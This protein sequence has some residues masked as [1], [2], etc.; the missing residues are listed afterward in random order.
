MGRT[1]PECTGIIAKEEL[2][3]VATRARHSRRLS[4]MNARVRAGF[5]GAPRSSELPSLHA[6]RGTR[7]L[8]LGGSSLATPDRIRDVGR[9]VAEHGERH[10]AIVVVSAFQGV[11]NQLLDC[12]RAR[13]TARSRVRTG[14]RPDRRAPSFRDRQSL[15]LPPGTLR[16]A[17][18]S[19]SSSASC[20]TRC[21]ASA[22]SATVRRPRS[23]SRP[24]S[25]SVCR[26]SSCPRI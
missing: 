12:A 13:G 21:T 9:I 25:A 6:F 26:R 7:V 10:P 2:C 4:V 24:A 5:D 18:S 22:C 8:K 3:R 20:A 16:S 14:L 15:R 19:T 11:T 23:T 17:R 1:S